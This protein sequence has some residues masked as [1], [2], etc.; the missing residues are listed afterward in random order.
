MH[1]CSEHGVPNLDLWRVLKNSGVKPTPGTEGKR[2]VFS[3]TA[4]KPPCKKI[5]S[6]AFL[7]C[8]HRREP[9]E[10][11]QGGT[12][13]TPSICGDL[14]R[15]ERAVIIRSVKASTLTAEEW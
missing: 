10:Q 1:F 12:F 5:P 4:A 6:K 3:C 7:T 13:S 14:T 8:P 15:E 9:F 2:V 11:K